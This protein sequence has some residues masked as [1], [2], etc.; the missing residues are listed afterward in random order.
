MPKPFL[1][2]DGVIEHAGITEQ[3]MAFMVMR[4]PARAFGFAGD[5]LDLCICAMNGFNA[6]FPMAVI[7]TPIR[8]HCQNMFRRLME[9]SDTALCI[10]H[11]SLAGKRMLAAA[12]AASLLASC[13]DDF[14]GHLDNAA[15]A[16]R[17]KTEIDRFI[18]SMFPLV[19]VD[20]G[21]PR[22]ASSNERIELARS[23]F[24]NDCC[25]APDNATPVLDCLMLVAIGR[26]IAIPAEHCQ[27]IAMIVVSAISC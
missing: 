6:R 17:S 3:G 2:A 8:V 23:K 27:A 14:I 9:R 10:E 12:D 18:E 5:D 16:H 21:H 22:A 11:G 15:S 7:I 19:P 4:M 1:E 24:Y 26:A 13:T 25:L 20:A